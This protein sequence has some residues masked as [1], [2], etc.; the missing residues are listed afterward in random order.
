VYLLLTNSTFQEKQQLRWADEFSLNPNTI[1][2]TKIYITNYYC[3]LETKLRSFQIKVNLRVTVTNVQLHG[4][5]MIENNFCCFCKTNPETMMHL[6]CDCYHVCQ[7][8]E[9]VT[10][11]LCFYFKRSIMLNCFLLN[12]RFLIFKHKIFK[13][14]SLLLLF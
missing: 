7:F 13:Q 3:T 2:W 11:W 5:G 14:N 10:S 1:N 9:D 12:A 8:W 4:F 6:F